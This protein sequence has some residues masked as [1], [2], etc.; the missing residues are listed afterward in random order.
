MP[1]VTVIE[2]S[3]IANRDDPELVLGLR[4]A[5]TTRGIT[6]LEGAEVAA[7]EPRPNIGAERRTAGRGA[8]TYWSRLAAGP[9]SRR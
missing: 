7:A 3:T 9:I 6:I 5:L 2:A 8:R 4:L 1:A